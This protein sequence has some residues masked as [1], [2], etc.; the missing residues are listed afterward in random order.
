HL[1][2]QGAELFQVALVAALAREP[3]PVEDLGRRELVA[4]PSVE[5]DEA[6]ELRG[7]CERDE[8][9]GVLRARL[10]DRE[11]EILR[12]QAPD[13]RLGIGMVEDGLDALFA[14]ESGEGEPLLRKAIERQGRF[15]P[16]S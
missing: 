5:I 2:V 16:P 3:Q 10:L 8:L 13:E 9:A 15:R 14:L 1:H 6:T 11:V 7:R 12:G 4:L